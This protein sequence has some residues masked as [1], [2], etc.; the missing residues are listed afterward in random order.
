MWG[1]EHQDAFDDLISQ[2]NN[3]MI[4]ALPNPSKVICVFTDAS[5]KFYGGLV[6]QVPPSQLNLPVKDQ[7][8]EPLGFSSGAFKGSQLRWGTPEKEGF[9]VVQVVRTF[10]YILLQAPQ[11]RIF[12]DHLNL[13]YIYN[14]HSVDSSLARHVVHKLQRWALFLSVYNYVIEHIAG[15]LNSWADLL[16]RFGAG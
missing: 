3:L 2:I 15:E 1:S 6:T 12:T 8:H 13:K 7:Q 14:P 5:D 9:A 11:F 16:T 4:M 10:D